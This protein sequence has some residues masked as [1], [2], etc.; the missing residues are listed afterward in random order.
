MKIEAKARLQ[1]AVFTDKQLVS[2]AKAAGTQ[3]YGR[4]LMFKS[5]LERISYEEYVKRSEDAGPVV[6]T[7]HYVFYPST[8]E[9][10]DCADTKFTKKHVDTDGK[11]YVAGVDGVYVLSD[12]FKKTKGKPK[13]DQ[14]EYNRFLAAL[15]KSFPDASVKPVDKWERIFAYNGAKM[16]GQFLNRGVASS[17]SA[18]W[19]VHDGHTTIAKHNWK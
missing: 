4:S 13:I 3:L 17:G 9:G 12:P 15:K 5:R 2:I 11:I 8:G 19:L 7:F 6:D 18:A 14:T 10:V 1:S 16:V